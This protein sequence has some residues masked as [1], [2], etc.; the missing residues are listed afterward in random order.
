[1]YER[2]MQ[3]TV[4]RLAPAT[5]RNRELRENFLALTP[6]MIFYVMDGTKSVMHV[7]PRPAQD[8]KPIFCHDFLS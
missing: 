1:M 6:T 5:H 8:E 2:N 4:H 7:R 3:T